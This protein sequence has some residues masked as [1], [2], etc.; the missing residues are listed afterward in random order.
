MVQAG[1]GWLGEEE[2][3]AG[4]WQRHDLAGDDLW[5]GQGWGLEGRLPCS[6]SWSAR[7]CQF[8]QLTV[9]LH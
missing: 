9:T 3:L 2:F 4:V 5:L 1:Q 7:T 6:V 8:L